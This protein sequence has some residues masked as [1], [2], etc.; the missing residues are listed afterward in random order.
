MKE[1]R[2]TVNGYTIVTCGG[3]ITPKRWEIYD[4][5][6]HF[7]AVFRKY[8]DAKEACLKRYF[9]KWSRSPLIW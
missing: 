1:V 8:R 7:V 2:R 3:Y 9:P 4:E 5:D 6:E